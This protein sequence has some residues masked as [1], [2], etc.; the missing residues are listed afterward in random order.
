MCERW[1]TIE[2][3]FGNRI[4]ELRMLAH[5]TQ[6]ELGAVAQLHR[7]YISDLERGMRNVSLRTI[8]KLAQAL[9]VEIRDLF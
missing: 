8:E 5:L 9:Q 7:N 6:E 4:R 3:R 1:D 2:V